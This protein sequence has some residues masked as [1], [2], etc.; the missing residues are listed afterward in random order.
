MDQE[1]VTTV[2]VQGLPVPIVASTE[3]ETFY[4]PP[5]EWNNGMPMMI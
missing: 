4:A 5:V 3:A 2:R 1:L